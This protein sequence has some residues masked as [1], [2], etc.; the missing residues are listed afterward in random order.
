MSFTHTTT[1]ISSNRIHSPIKLRSTHQAAHY[2]CFEPKTLTFTIT[3]KKLQK[4]AR[5]AIVQSCNRDRD[6]NH[7]QSS[8]KTEQ[9]SEKHTDKNTK[10][11]PRT[12]SF[13][14]TARK[15]IL[16]SCNPIRCVTSQI[17]CIISSICNHPTE[18]TLTKTPKKSQNSIFFEDRT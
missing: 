11:I 13:L 10:I 15:T 6:I 16:Q 7:L 14:K 12:R 17:I 5:S 3:P 4:I 2:L 1:L 9:Q 8:N 18:N